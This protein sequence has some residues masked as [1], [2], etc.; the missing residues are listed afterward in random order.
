MVFIRCH[1]DQRV[2]ARAGGV[3]LFEFCSGLIEKFGC[4]IGFTM[5]VCFYC[6]EEC[7]L[8][9]LLWETRIFPKDRERVDGLVVRTSSEVAFG[10]HQQSAVGEGVIAKLRTQAVGELA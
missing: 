1:R 5:F 9:A 4:G 6:L 10:N 8:A 3:F 2:E 7:R